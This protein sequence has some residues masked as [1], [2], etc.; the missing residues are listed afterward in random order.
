MNASINILKALGII[1]VVCGHLFSGVPKDLIYLF[2]MPLFFFLSGYLFK[3]KPVKS[4][5]KQKLVNLIL[6]YVAYLAVFNIPSFAGFVQNVILQGKHELAASYLKHFAI[7]VYGG[8]SLKDITGVFWFVTCLFFTQQ[9]Y[10]LLLKRRNINIHIVVLIAYLLAIFNQY[11]LAPFPFPL[12]LNV[13]LG[14]IL[15]FHLGYEFKKAGILQT[16]HL[17]YSLPLSLVGIALALMKIPVWFDMKVASYG[18]PVLSIVI[19]LS[20]ILVATSLSGWIARIPKIT[21]ALSYIGAASMTIMSLHQLFHI[22]VADKFG[23]TAPLPVF[24]LC[25]LG[26]LVLHV[27]FTQVPIF[28][29][30]FLGDLNEVKKLIQRWRPSGEPHPSAAFLR[31]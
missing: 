7:Q 19:S 13:V 15:F 23:L 21:P 6:P 28:K 11:V 27:G 17:Y 14:A 20:L 26:P 31:K 22:K 12:A 1:T 10:N 24:L 16:K 4:F 9:T 18:L 30:L 8:Q 2:H 25:L 29:A 3:E 5:F